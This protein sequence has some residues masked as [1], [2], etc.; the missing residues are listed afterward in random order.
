MV[1]WSPPGNRQYVGR[2][3]PDPF[4]PAWRESWAPLRALQ[5]GNARRRRRFPLTLR[6]LA[7]TLLILDLL[8]LQELSPHRRRRVPSAAPELGE[9]MDAFEP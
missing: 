9:A 8:V 3:R 2:D 6:S 1:S 5:E 7:G 4:G